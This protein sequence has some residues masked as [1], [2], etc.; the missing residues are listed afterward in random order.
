[1][2]DLNVLDSSGWLAF[3]TDGP[4]ATAFAPVAASTDRLIVPSITL[5]EVFKHVVRERGEPA[6]FVVVAHMRQG[7]VV[8][9]DAALALDAARVSTALRLPMADSILLATARHYDA[10][11]WTQDADFDGLDHVHYVPA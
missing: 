3:F 1:M 10:T 8:D 4:N 9:L 5:Y 2:T 7:R 6:A 11:L